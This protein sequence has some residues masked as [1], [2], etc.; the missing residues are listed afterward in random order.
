MPVNKLRPPVIA[1]TIP[2][3]TDGK[4]S[5]PF[6][7]NRSVGLEDFDG[8]VL[9]IKTP[10][11][12]DVQ[13]I[14][15][16]VLN[17]DLK[18]KICQEG[19]VTFATKESKNLDI[20]KSNE[21]V[22]EAK[23]L[24]FNKLVLSLYYKFQL[25]YYKG[26]NDDI[27]IGYYSTIAVGKYTSIPKISINTLQKYPNKNNAEYSYT[28]VYSQKN[29]INDS[30]MNNVYRNIDSE[31]QIGANTY[32]TNETPSDEYKSVI[33]GNTLNYTYT[34]IN[35]ISE[36]SGYKTTYKGTY[37]AQRDNTEKLYSSQLFLYDENGFI[38]YQSDE[39]L[40]NTLTDENEYEATETFVVN[41]ELDENSIYLLSWKV[42]T[43]NNLT[44]ESDKYRIVNKKKLDNGF[45][46]DITAT[47]NRDN[48]YID[49]DLKSK[50]NMPET[51]HY[52]ILRHAS[53]NFG[54]WNEMFRF[55]LEQEVPTRHVWK[56]LTVEQ[57][58]E[59]TYAIQQYIIDEDDPKQTP[60]FYTQRK[61]SNKVVA[62]FDDMFLFD[63]D[64]QL[65]LKY[66][67]KVASFKKTLLEAKI[68]TIGSKYPF[69]YRNATVDYKEFSISGLISYLSDEEEFFTKGLYEI[70]NLKRDGTPTTQD[71]SI[72]GT[73]TTSLTSKNIYTEREF[74]LAV[75]DW[76]NNGKPKLFRSATEGNYIVRLLNTSMSPTDS[77]GRMLHTVS[78]T[79]YEINK[80]TY[81]TLLE[82]NIINFDVFKR[83]QIN[84][85]TIDLIDL[86]LTSSSTELGKYKIEKK[87][88]DTI[89]SFE[90][91]GIKPGTK[92][93]I[94]DDPNNVDLGRTIIIGPTGTYRGDYNISKFSIEF[95]ELIT[96]T[97]TYQYWGN[98]L[99]FNDLISDINL[100]EYPC[101]QYFSKYGKNYGED[102]IEYLENVKE[103][104]VDIYNINI[105]KKEEKN[106]IDILPLEKI[107][108][109]K[110]T[111][112]DTWA[113]NDVL[114]ALVK[115]TQEESKKEQEN[116]VALNEETEEKFTFDDQYIYYTE[117]KSTG[118]GNKVYYYYNG[119]DYK[120]LNATYIDDIGEYVI[121]DDTPFYFEIN[122]NKNYLQNSGG[123][124]FRNRD[125]S[126][127]TF[128][129]GFGVFA[130]FSYLSR[131]IVY[132]VENNIQEVKD[133]FATYKNNVDSFLINLDK[134]VRNTVEGNYL[135]FLGSVTE[136][137][138]RDIKAKNISDLDNT[139]DGRKAKKLIAALGEGG[140]TK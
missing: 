65:K 134:D 46:G 57:G 78:S 44:Y 35:Q 77:V 15:T 20:N 140:E 19:I 26:N 43:C 108:V 95:A 106:L 137:L 121:T 79:A 82:Y 14:Q 120:A 62:D 83:K 75:L 9:K 111:A 122:N 2:A 114:Q 116:E 42:T 85:S 18:K 132:L 4:I 67:P 58:I 102:L 71:L 107:G 127:E 81:E 54:V 117:L 72:Y 126:I 41:K 124:I 130:E 105:K 10:Q 12:K 139:Y 59:Y 36:T 37:V 28:C 92:I 33:I 74:K 133:A 89:E 93:I 101:V 119:E 128:K 115:L 29:D 69:V 34:K 11:G 88:N 138:K 39:I 6:S 125:L 51:G 40:H 96:G 76:L 112:F 21:L 25:A 49:I 98:F 84:I 8:F 47:L 135:A 1:G 63:G 70:L 27:V 55:N 87:F 53:N 123:R 31:V 32:Y 104:I 100:K 97:F 113:V 13:T 30:T 118:L 136:A 16:D 60:K 38:V 94:N 91:T 99:S 23:L 103:T 109:D 3:F 110:R 129:L 66:N 80:N 86:P 48:G 45:Q 52:V 64:K 22:L 56:D 24:D 50:N 17:S 73:P 5:V 61:E 68:D 7:M 131:E 90:F